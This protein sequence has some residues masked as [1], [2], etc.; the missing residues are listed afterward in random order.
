[1]YL[2]EAHGL[3]P[4]S[5]RVLEVGK[6]AKDNHTSDC[7]Q[8]SLKVSKSWNRACMQAVASQD[9]LGFSTAPRR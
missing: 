7:M 5:S 2:E 3:G 9:F 6:E 1:M 8:A 4:V